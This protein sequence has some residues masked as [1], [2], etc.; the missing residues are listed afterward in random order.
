MFTG[1]AD[2]DVENWDIVKCAIL[3]VFKK[4]H[5]IYFFEET[6]FFNFS[7]CIHFISPMSL[8]GT[9]Q[10]TFSEIDGQGN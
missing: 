5:S 4:N 8:P 9:H 2:R 3:S 1:Y 10:W 6:V 7:P